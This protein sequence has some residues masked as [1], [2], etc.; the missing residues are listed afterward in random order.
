MH[1]TS[2]LVRETWQMRRSQA[3]HHM[4]TNDGEYN[5]GLTV[6]SPNSRVPNSV[7]L[8]FKWGEDGHVRCVQTGEVVE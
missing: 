1:I 3:L 8:T 5:V 2:E 7:T 6:P 4:A